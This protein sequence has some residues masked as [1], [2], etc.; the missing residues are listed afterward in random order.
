MALHKVLV[1]HIKFKVTLQKPRD[2]HTT[3]F[4]VSLL[5]APAPKKPISSHIV[6]DNSKMGTV[7]MSSRNVLARYN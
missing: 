3:G 1:V 6:L 2:K 7:G 4:A 5:P